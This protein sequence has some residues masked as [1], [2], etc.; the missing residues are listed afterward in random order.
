MSYKI[1]EVEGIGPAYGKEL[2][3]VGIRSTDDLLKQCATAAGRQKI[4]DQISVSSGQLLKWADMADLMRLKGV[5]RQYGELL[6]AAGVDTVKEL[7][8]RVA[9]N[10]TQ[11]LAETNAEKKLAK[12]VPGE[13]MVQAWIDAAMQTQPKITH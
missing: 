12:T 7:R 5:G 1:E 13:S 9:A 10:L 4:S 8:T 6:K 11:T 2:A 3:T